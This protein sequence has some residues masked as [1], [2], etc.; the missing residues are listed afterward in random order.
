MMPGTVQLIQ[1]AGTFNA[2]ESL[3]ANML[4]LTILCLQVSAF[5][6]LERKSGC[7]KCMQ[8]TCS[9]A[10]Q[11]GGVLLAAGQRAHVAGRARGRPLEK[12]TSSADAP[13]AEA[14][15]LVGTP[16]RAWRARGRSRAADCPPRPTARLPWPRARPAFGRYYV[17]AAAALRAVLAA[18]AAALAGRLCGLST[19]QLA[20]P[21]QLHPDC[22]PQ[23]G[24]SASHICES[25]LCKQTKTHSLCKQERK[26]Y[27]P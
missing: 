26:A 5:T 2:M 4:G 25:R 27:M 1:I 17:L 21:V 3:L 15:P 8:R 9:K 18:V 11:A 24:A 7:K 23:S 19:L 14:L 6:A 16:A 22:F 13:S 20:A 12:G 10:F